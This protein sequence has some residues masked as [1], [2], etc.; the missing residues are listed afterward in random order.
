MLRKCGDFLISTHPINV[1]TAL[2]SLYRRY[3]HIYVYKDQYQQL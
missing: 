1:V 3:K 2:L